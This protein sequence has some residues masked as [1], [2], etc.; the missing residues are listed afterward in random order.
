MPYACRT[1]WA[2]RQTGAPLTC[3]LSNSAQ[4]KPASTSQEELRRERAFATPAPQVWPEGMRTATRPRADRGHGERHGEQP[5]SQAAP[6]EHRTAQGWAPSPRWCQ[7]HGAVPSLPT[8]PL[9]SSR[10]AQPGNAASTALEAG[11]PPRPGAPQRRPGR[12][13]GGQRGRAPS[14]EPRAEA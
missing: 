9:P 11:L 6:A 4:H 7:A 12:A 8:H 5:G 1:T 3:C 14:A 13:R 2:D 10:P